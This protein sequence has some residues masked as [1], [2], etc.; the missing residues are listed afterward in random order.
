MRTVLIFTFCIFGLTAQAQSPVLD[1]IRDTRTVTLGYRE[2]SVPF[3]YLDGEQKPVGY[4]LDICRDIVA[5]IGKKLGIDRLNVALNPVTSATRIPLMTNGTIDLECGSTTNTK[6]RQALVSFSPTTYVATTNALTKKSDGSKTFADL[7]GKRI[8]TTA[9]TTSVKLINDLSASQNLN[10]SILVAKDHAEAFLMLETG[11][12]SA[13]IMDDII[14]AGL[15]ATSRT[16][17]DYVISKDYLSLEPYGIMFR[18]DDAAL[19]TLVDE[20]VAGLLKS[21]RMKALYAKWFEAPI[22]PRGISLQLPMSDALA[23]AAATP[24][25]SPDPAAYR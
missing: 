10:Y 9:G 5:A 2:S 15:A 19:K 20:A 3:S 7:A 6:E 22:P 11:R 1:K 18:R 21:D 8:A 24:T 4:S 16:P 23:K 13:F 17:A 12:V 25:D 14:L